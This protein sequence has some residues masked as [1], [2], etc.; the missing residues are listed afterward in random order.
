M[1]DSN[2][3]ADQFDHDLKPTTNTYA[4]A[5][6]ES[7]GAFELPHG[8]NTVS[9]IHGYLNTLDEDAHPPIDPDEEDQISELMGSDEISG[10]ASSH[11]DEMDPM[12]DLS[13]GM[14]TH[15]ANT[16]LVD[17]SDDSD[18]ETEE[19]CRVCRGEPDQNR[20]L[21]HPCLCKGSIKYVHQECLMTWLRHSNSTRCEVCK[22]PFKFAPIYAED[23]PPK[24]SVAELVLGL[25]NMLMGHIKVVGRFGLVILAW[26]LV[27]PYCTSLLTKLYF[28]KSLK[29]ILLEMKQ[30][31]TTADFFVDVVQGGLI[32]G[33][34]IILS[35]ALLLFRDFL[36]FN[37]NALGEG[38][39]A[40]AQDFGVQ[41]EAQQAPMDER[42]PMD[43][44]FDAMD[45]GDDHD[46]LAEA[47]VQPQ[48]P[49]PQQH[50]RH[51][52]A[53]HGVELNQNAHPPMQENLGGV[54][55]DEIQNPNP[56]LPEPRARPPP[57]ANDP[58]NLLAA[59]QDADLLN[60]LDNPQE[61]VDFTE[62]VGLRGS[63]FPFLENVLH[64]VV[65]NSL[66]LGF[67]GLLP[68]NIGRFVVV[69]AGYEP[70]TLTRQIVVDSAPWL[71]EFYMIVFGYI[72]FGIFSWIWILFSKFM[73][74]YL[75][76][77]IMTIPASCLK[78][79][80][81]LYSFLKVF[82]LMI[83][84]LGVV[85]YFFGWVL[86]LYGVGLF[87]R[88][89]E[90]HEYHMKHDQL[91]YHLS[92]W[93]VGISFLIY[94]AKIISVVRSVVRPHVLWFLMNVED[95]NFHPIRLM[96]NNSMAWHFRRIGRSF[97]MYSLFLLFVMGVPVL[98]WSDMFPTLVPLSVPEKSIISMVPFETLYH[99]AY[100]QYVLQRL[101][102]GHRLK[103]AVH[104]WFQNVGE[105]LDLED[106]LLP[107][108]GEEVDGQAP[109]VKPP[110]FRVRVAALVMLFLITMMM[111]HSFIVL[112]PLMM[113]HFIFGL[114]K[115][116][117]NNDL[118]VITHGAFITFLFA[119]IVRYSLDDLRQARM[120]QLVGRFQG[121]VSKF[122]KTAF[123]MFTCVV[124][125]PMLVGSLVYLSF[126]RSIYALHL[127][128]FMHMLSV[129]SLSTS[130]LPRHH[131]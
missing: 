51:H 107:V 118:H 88:N 12:H 14:G 129:S 50:P 31:W 38:F 17:V 48:P 73:R 67:S 78:F 75:G 85:P 7:I 70:K 59:G 93:A 4:T 35:L 109:V 1:D 99:L 13:Q 60:I 94:L 46:P 23:C 24:L 79:V 124:L 72:V 127:Q 111:I 64:V 115:I 106:Y 44:I 33:V 32:W 18:S 126:V 81:F 120:M 29:T 105:L 56:N 83:L 76:I 34:I 19:I 82:I 49:I 25:L 42:D 122:L 47:G 63:L 40:L 121:I 101:N 103:T 39:A 2:S 30:P 86:D 55:I 113:G 6:E 41:A 27:V 90:S 102:F 71:E 8:F 119:D 22:Y 3:E 87:G 21:F 69:L 43:E 96:L 53:P 28:V 95:P 66:F 89:W 91:V 15:G 92:H 130:P 9:N 65:F 36:R 11:S 68:F 74:S 80:I 98:I 97:V 61:N 108:E 114:V 100:I 116:Q 52:H 123:F 58:A 5:A 20:P 117:F 110:N 62:L 45:E 16:R 125:V 10:S 54:V 128:P 57:Q 131:E 37:I 84:E 77:Q 104:R 26:F 112:V